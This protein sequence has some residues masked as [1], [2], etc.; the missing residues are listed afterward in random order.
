MPAPVTF[1]IFRDGRLINETEQ[2]EQSFVLDGGDGLVLEVLDDP[3]AKP[4][5]AF[6]GK[7][8]LTWFATPDTDHYRVEEFVDA[9]W[10]LRKRISDLGEGYFKH[11]TRFVEDVTVHQFRIIPIGTNQNPG[12]I[13]LFS[14]LMVRHPD[15]PVVN[16]SY[17]NATETLT[18]TE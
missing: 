7:F 4:I 9:V 11:T 10:V 13:T 2:T 17:S 8:T 3:N 18:I 6:P 16:F 1:F 5:T 15:P 12:T 14:A